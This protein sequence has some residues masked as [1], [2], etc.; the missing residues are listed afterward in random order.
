MKTVLIAVLIVNALTCSIARQQLNGRFVVKTSWLNAG[1]SIVVYIAGMCGQPDQAF[2]KIKLPFAASE[3]YMRY[4][5][6]G[7]SPKKI[8]AWLDYVGLAGCS[9]VACSV[10]AK[11]LVYSGL[12]ISQRA[13]EIYLLNPCAY[14]K[15]LRR[16]LLWPVRIG[17]VA[18]EALSYALGW[19]AIIPLPPHGY[20][21]LA[22]LADQTF[23]IG[24]DPAGANDYFFAP[25]SMIVVS[26]HDE[27]LV[28]GADLY[29][30]YLGVDGRAK[31]DAGHADFSSDE[32]AK[33]YREAM[34]E[35]AAKKS[36]II[37][38]RSGDDW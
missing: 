23:W 17:G 38:R 13:E 3:I 10:G 9:I 6:F 12:S 21:S 2:D 26:E 24:F 34:G 37:M 19:I 8:G 30:D 14:S 5:M 22:L 28:A 36:R 4:S 20:Y 31:I 32:G 15:S 35:L 7:F 1:G 33:K 29:A 11:P 16:R 25:N 27:F 18:L